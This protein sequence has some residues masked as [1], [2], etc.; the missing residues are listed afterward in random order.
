[1]RSGFLV[2]FL[3]HF[4]LA[5]GFL[6]VPADPLSPLAGLAGCGD[7]ALQSELLCMGLHLRED[8]TDGVGR[9]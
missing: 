8:G 5:L 7:F 6:S 4:W 3:L 2:V 9:S 1:M